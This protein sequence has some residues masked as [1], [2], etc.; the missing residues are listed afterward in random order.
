MG[1]TLEVVTFEIR[2]LGPQAFRLYLPVQD[3]TTVTAYRSLS[4]TKRE[5]KINY[6]ASSGRSYLAL[7]SR[8]LT[9]G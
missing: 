4:A 9:V 5:Q 1:R 2:A 3:Q 8:S 7:P 6:T